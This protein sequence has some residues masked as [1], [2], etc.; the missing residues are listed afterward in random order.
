LTNDRGIL[1]GT[2]EERR[3]LTREDVNKKNLFR[4]LIYGWLPIPQTIIP[5]K[6]PYYLW[7]SLD[8]TPYDSASDYNG[9]LLDQIREAIRLSLKGWEPIDRI[10]V[11]FPEVLTVASYCI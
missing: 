5:P 1:R 11:W 6:R 7:S 8:I 3:V 9:K 10:G 4:Y 2:R